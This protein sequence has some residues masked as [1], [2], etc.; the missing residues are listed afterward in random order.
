LIVESPDGRI[1]LTDQTGKGVEF[2]VELPL[3]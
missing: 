3:A 2:F 1:D